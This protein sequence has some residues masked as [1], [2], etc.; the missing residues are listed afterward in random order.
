[1]S[2]KKDHAEVTTNML[3]G[4]GINWLLTLF[5][6]GTSPGYVTFTTLV[7]M[8]ASYLRSY[9]IR[10]IFRNYVRGDKS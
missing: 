3:V 9:T 1:M 4:A 8:V 10:R 5:L 2:K 6:F 7:F